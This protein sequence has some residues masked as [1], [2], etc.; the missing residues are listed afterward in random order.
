MTR[1]RVISDGGAKWWSKGVG[2]GII[3]GSG[4]ILETEEDNN[5]YLR[6]TIKSRIL[7]ARATEL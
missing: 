7:P 6:V 1:R 5:S 4:Y 3:E 2:V